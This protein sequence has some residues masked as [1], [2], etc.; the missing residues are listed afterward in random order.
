MNE[1][2]ET[3]SAP[4]R[5]RTALVVRVSFEESRLAAA[6]LATA[7]EQVLPRPRRSKVSTTPRS[8][9]AGQPRPH[10]VGRSGR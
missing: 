2:Q 7:Y 6:Y 4:R 1:R 5:G 3:A 9:A 8:A 10:A